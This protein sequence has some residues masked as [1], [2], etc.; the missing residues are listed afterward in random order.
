MSLLERARLYLWTPNKIQTEHL[1]SEQ[2]SH[3]AREITELCEMKLKFKNSLK[4]LHII[5]TVHLIIDYG[6]PTNAQ[7]YNCLY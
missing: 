1:S 6:T 5:H 4:R 2:R 3:P 7:K